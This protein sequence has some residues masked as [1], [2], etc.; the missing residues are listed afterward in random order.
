MF[1][2]TILYAIFIRPDK[3]FTFTIIAIF[4]ARTATRQFVNAYAIPHNFALKNGFPKNKDQTLL[5]ATNVTMVSHVKKKHEAMLCDCLWM[6]RFKKQL[7]ES[8]VVTQLDDRHEGHQLE[9]I[10]PLAYQENRPMT[11]ESRETMLD[12]V[13]HSSASLSTI[14]S[15]LNTTYGLSFNRTYDYTQEKGTWSH[16]L[17][18]HP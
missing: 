4:P 1:R 13:R 9:G 3:D 15:V 7:N 14:A 8:W 2:S 11:A 5:L 12:L 17:H 18:N 16:T 6:V 10:N